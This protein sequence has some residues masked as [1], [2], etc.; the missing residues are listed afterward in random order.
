MSTVRRREI[1]KR[2][3][4]AAVLRAADLAASCLRGAL[5]PVDL[6]AVCFVRAIGDDLFEWL[7]GGSGWWVKRASSVE[8]RGLIYC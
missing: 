5:P 1:V 3:T 6:R 2:L 8:G 4:A 7:S